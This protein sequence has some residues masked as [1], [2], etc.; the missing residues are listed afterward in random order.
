MRTIAARKSQKRRLDATAYG[1]DLEK[2]AHLGG[3]KQLLRFRGERRVMQRVLDV[4]LAE[5]VR[6]AAVHQELRLRGIAEHFEP[7]V[8]RSAGKRREIDV[9]GD[10]LLPGMRE[11]VGVRAMAVMAHEG[12]GR[13]LRMEI[14]AARKAIVE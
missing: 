2:L 8:H 7:G 12:A 13:A 14:L 1:E 6:D 4:R 11:H 3:R 5:H 10:V 9:R